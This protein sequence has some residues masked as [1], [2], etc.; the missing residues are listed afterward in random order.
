MP[1]PDP[2]W[3]IVPG[4]PRPPRDVTHYW[5]DGRFPCLHLTDEE[6]DDVMR[7]AARRYADLPA[8][9]PAQVRARRAAD[10]ARAAKPVE[11]PT[12]NWRE[13]D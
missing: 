13:E 2:N 11:R 6:F 1:I 3:C 7:R 5:E 8:P 12:T 9:D 10:A 4:L